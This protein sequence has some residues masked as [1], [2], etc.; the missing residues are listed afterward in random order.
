[1][2]EVV[3]RQGSREKRIDLRPLMPRRLLIFLLGFLGFQ[4][5]E[6]DASDAVLRADS[7]AVAEAD[8][9]EEDELDGEVEE[10]K[11]GVGGS[12]SRYRSLSDPDHVRS[13]SFFIVKS[14]GDAVENGG[15]V[16]CWFS[17]WG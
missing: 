15:F 5:A 16:G 8:V 7:D 12:I 17:F 1:M 2:T 9:E 3:V 13:S 10:G 14:S 11:T 4:R 6:G